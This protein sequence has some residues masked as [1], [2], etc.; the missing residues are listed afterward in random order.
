[1]VAEAARHQG[2]GRT[3]VGAD[4]YQAYVLRSDHL[5]KSVRDHGV[6]GC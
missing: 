1:V 5:L 6:P 3:P 2:I 4:T